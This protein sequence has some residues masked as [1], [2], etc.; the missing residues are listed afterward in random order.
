MSVVGA[1]FSNPVRTSA[2]QTCFL[3]CTGTAAEWRRRVNARQD[4]LQLR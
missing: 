1:I 2:H 3:I 4:F